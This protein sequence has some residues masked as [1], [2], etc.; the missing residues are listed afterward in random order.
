MR[1]FAECWS[2]FEIVQQVAALPPVDSDMTDQVFKDLYL[3]D[4]LGT[5]EADPGYHGTPKGE[6]AL[7]RVGQMNNIRACVMDIV[8]REIIFA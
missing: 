5:D 4:S 7:W 3:F 2:D 6:N 1:K 8:E